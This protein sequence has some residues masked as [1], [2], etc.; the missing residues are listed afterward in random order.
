VH[1]CTCYFTHGLENVSKR[2]YILK[3]VTVALDGSGHSV[4]EVVY[5]SSLEIASKLEKIN[6]FMLRELLS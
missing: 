1:F 2:A 6:F 4:L 5:T 3:E